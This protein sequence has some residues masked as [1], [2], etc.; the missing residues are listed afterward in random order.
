MQAAARLRGEGDAAAEAVDLERGPGAFDSLHRDRWYLSC[1]RRDPPSAPPA[2]RARELVRGDRL[3]AREV[4]EPERGG[5]VVGEALDRGPRA[6][7]ERRGDHLRDLGRSFAGLGVET[8]RYASAPTRLCEQV[9]HDRA[10]A[11][12]LADL[13][14]QR[15]RRV[16]ATARARGEGQARAR[17]P[18]SRR[19]ALR[20][21]GVGMPGAWTR[22]PAYRL[23]R[24]EPA[25]S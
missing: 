4:R 9:E 7:A 16:R 19:A 18:H 11:F 22:A 12:G 3:E 1:G 5:A 24:Q 21:A 13:R 10:H 17:R 15:A 20:A 23:H 8:Q 14:G 2:L 6:L 25:R